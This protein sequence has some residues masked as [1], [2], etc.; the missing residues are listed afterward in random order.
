MYSTGRV[1]FFPASFFKAQCI[2]LRVNPSLS[3]KGHTHPLTAKFFFLVFCFVYVSDYVPLN[4]TRFGP[5]RNMD[6]VYT[7][8]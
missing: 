4:E 7:L 1:T 2:Y 5:C 6:L 8:V 3:V